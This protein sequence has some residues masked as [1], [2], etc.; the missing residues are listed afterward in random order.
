LTCLIVGIDP[1]STSSGVVIFDVDFFKIVLAEEFNNEQ[2]LKVLRGFPYNIEVESKFIFDIRD[3]EDL[4]I[5]DIE[6]MGLSVGRSVFETAKWIG[7]F[8]EA[9]EKCTNRKSI[10]VF[11]SDEKI[12]LCGTRTYVNPVNGKRKS[13]GD[14]QIRA[15]LIERFDPVGGGKIPQI[16]TKKN[17][18]P[19]YGVKGHCWQALSVLITGIEISKKG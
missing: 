19:L 8:S 2:L 15:S 6:G 17:P 1:G 11:R 10:E 13:V 5:E 18:G 7:R 16:G 14:K 12:I 3:M 9:Y 4:Y